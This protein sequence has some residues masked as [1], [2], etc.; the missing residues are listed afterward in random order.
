[1]K[2]IIDV[3]NEIGKEV[4]LTLKNNNSGK[5]YQDTILLYS[6]I[7]NMLKYLIAQKECWN[8]NSKT[9]DAAIN[10]ENETGMT[11]S[12]SELKV[13]FDAIREKAFDLNFNNAIN[14]ARSL[15]IITEELKEHL[16]TIRK[17]RND[18]IH[19][20]YLFEN[21]NDAEKMRTELELPAAVMAELVPIFE[22]LL[23]DL[24]GFTPEDLPEIFE[25][26]TK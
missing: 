20:L 12:D 9:V 14:K 26:L 6:L 7:E 2:N 11:V 10:K 16:H 22:R 24:I 1:M 5:Y 19:Q 13:D 25:P 18:I 23:F 8:E 3:T 15:K 21:R 17:R 4:D